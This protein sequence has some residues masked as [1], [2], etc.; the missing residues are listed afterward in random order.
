MAESVYFVDGVSYDEAAQAD[1]NMRL[2]PQGVLPESGS[3]LAVTASGGMNVSVAAGE[4]LVQGFLYK[5]TTSKSL[6][7]AANSS[8]STRVDAAVL[9]L[10]RGANTLTAVIK[11]GTPGAGAP[12]LTQ[13]A[14]GTWEF[15][16]AN[17]S[18]GN[19]VV[20]IITANITDQRV[21]SLWTSTHIGTDI[22]R[23]A[24]LD[25]ESVARAA[26][27][28]ILA[29]G[30]PVV[31]ARIDPPD[32]ITSGIGVA[33]VTRVSA[34]LYDITFTSPFSNSNYQ[35]LVTGLGQ[36]TEIRA[37]IQGQSNS[38]MRVN[39]INASGVSADR[40]FNLVIWA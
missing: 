34:G 21:M 14:G 1:F 7:V 11:Q 26:A 40:A 10:D 17:V 16:L 19:G 5:N 37:Y 4:A 9:K 27:D 6:P 35:A 15:P 20:S 33:Y 8:G 32:I 31:R 38:A 36:P 18:V 30:L 23:K 24:A 3:L 25:A 12:T 39:T 13:V 22:S 29:A 28:A 2:R